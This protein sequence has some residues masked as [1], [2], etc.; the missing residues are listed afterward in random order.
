MKS[1]D[2][3]IKYGL[4]L[5]VFL[6]PLWFLPLT[7]SPLVINKQILLAVFAFLLFILWMVKIII[8]G[9]LSLNW[10][11]L[12]LMVFLLLITVGICTLFSSAKIQS[13]WGMDFNPDTLFSFILYTIVFFLFANL[14]KKESL[15]S[16][17][18]TFLASAGTL[19]L[20]FLIQILKPI[21]PWDFAQ[22]SS[23]NLI[24]SV[25]LLGIFLGGAF[26]TLITL[27]SG[28]QSSFVVIGGKSISK[29]ISQILVGLIGF[30]LFLSIFLINF[31]VVWMGIAFGSAIIIFRGLKNLSTINTATNPLKP[32]FLPVFIFVFALVLIFLKL[33]INNIVNL[34]SEISPTFQANFDITLKTLKEGTKNFILGSGPATFS[35]QYSLHRSVGSNFADFWQIRFDQ[36]NN[37]VLTLFTNLGILGILSVLGLIIVF[38]WQGFKNIISR[39]STSIN[40]AIFA[41]GFY[42][43][44]LWFFYS[45]SIPLCFITFLIM[46]LFV[47]ASSKTKEFSFTQS[48][49]KAFFI[50]LICIVFIVSSILGIYNISQKY[51][52][53]IIYAQGLNLINT[54]TFGL[55]EGIIKI[56]KATTLDPKD[57]YFR[58]LSQ[59]F[60]LKINE[61]LNNQD[62]TQEQKK[63]ELQRQTSNTEL[64]AISAVRINSKN[65]QNWFQLGSIYEN[66][67]LIGVKGAEDLAIL[68]YQKAVDLDPQ[69]PQT[70][71]NIARVY[72]LINDKGEAKKELERSLQLK[73]DFQPA[74]DLMT[75]IKASK[76]QLGE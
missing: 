33:P 24:G 31:W 7:I 23:F 26:V 13:F 29:R 53:A 50:M 11:K 75:Q 34:S 54:K 12:S 5:L 60:L 38:F 55:N 71:F 3:I 72:Y 16:V 20:L 65:S 62:L 76:E 51:A 25:H 9:K 4:Y 58:N 47:A 6:F 45:G 49:Q 68:N 66:F 10:G 61:I 57:S 37:V 30:L 43:L 69:N 73:P 44:V 40:T 27:I 63:E 74:I 8:S 21:F 2:K 22:S 59:A 42:F 64:S 28:N 17:L 19:S 15:L 1:L 56:N 14:I 48:P 46:G 36:G 41:G 70:F 39:G 32:L 35:Y 67:I 52:A 18:W